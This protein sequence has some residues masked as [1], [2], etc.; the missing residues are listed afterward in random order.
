M[1]FRV[2][3]AWTGEASSKAARA[4]FQLRLL[5]AVRRLSSDKA[6]IRLRGPRA[7]TSALSSSQPSSIKS[8]LSE[9]A[10][11]ARHGRLFSKRT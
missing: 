4:N 11:A 10:E 3:R 9:A 6:G 1:A 8:D 5:A 7:V 2:V